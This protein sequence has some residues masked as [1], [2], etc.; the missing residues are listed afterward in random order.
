MVSN[1]RTKLGEATDGTEEGLARGPLPGHQAQDSPQVH[2]RG[3]EPD[4]PWGNAERSGHLRTA[5]QPVLTWPPHK[6][7][8]LVLTFC[9]P[10]PNPADLLP[11]SP[12]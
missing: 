5:S 2:S 8:A 11:A 7:P 4:R 9:L 12:R 10:G 3:K 6:N 1:N